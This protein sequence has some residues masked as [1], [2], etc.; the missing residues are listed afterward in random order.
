MAK[1]LVE[2]NM[3][4]SIYTFGT[5]YL[6]GYSPDR[7]QWARDL[8]LISELH[9]NT[10]RVWL[11]WGILEPADGQVDFDYIDEI[12]KLA[13]QNHLR[14]IFL[15]HLH[16]APEWA[17]RKHRDCWYVDQHG[18]PFE[19]SAR[20]NTPSGGWPG[21]CPDHVVVQQLEE[22]F[23]K[24]VCEYVGDRAFA[25]EPINEPHAWVDMAQNP[26]G[27]FCF[28]EETR[29]LFR[30]WL[31]RRYG[32]LEALEKAWGH[33]FTDWQ[34]VRPPTWLFGYADTVDWRLFMTENI[35]ELVKRRTDCIRRYS[36]VQVIAHAWGGGTVTC[37]QLG[38]MAFD[39]WKNSQSLDKWGCSAFP[40]SIK[41]T[42]NV[43][44]SMDAT[45]SAAC[46]KEFWQSEL[47]AGDV[48]GGLRRGF[49]T[50]PE[51]FS[52]WC[53][54]AIGH[55]SK[56]L[57]FWQFRKESYGNESGAYGLTDYQGNPSPRALAA[58]K[59]AKTLN[60]HAELF[61]MAEMPQSE[62]A[63]LFSYQSIMLNWAEFRNNNLS[64]D[65]I[66]GYYRAF[67]EQN[68][69]VDI[70]HEEFTTAE[71]LARYKLVVLPCP[72]TLPQRITELLKD[73]ATNGGTVLSDPMLCLWDE[74]QRLSDHVPGNGLHTLFG[75]EEKSLATGSQNAFDVFANGRKIS[76]KNSFARE[77]WN[78]ARSD[79]RT[80]VANG[81]GEAMVVD[82]PCGAGHAVLSGLSLGNMASQQVSISDD[83]H[84]EGAEQVNEGASE[85]IL[86]VAN[87]AGVACP[88][89]TAPNIR[90][91]H[92]VSGRH[93]ILIAYDFQR[94]EAECA[95]R[96]TAAGNSPWK[97][98]LD[99]SEGVFRNGETMLSFKPNEIKVMLL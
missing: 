5:Q 30:A 19:P 3:E 53:W 69:P 10:I 38:T 1:S 88:F 78:V 72:F 85:L 48:S 33:R 41:H 34:D 79:V 75:C 32:T 14:V 94:K 44:L 16:S 25:Y 45:R 65:A 57:L 42:C 54:E 2:N 96:F 68:I 82:A 92:L 23:I 21:L 98:L 24:A 62:V 67:W 76:L 71:T 80:L 18:R 40:S 83:F 93:H 58:S 47:S 29:N 63:I 52:I 12:L 86:E 37:G 17:I 26:Q 27:Y 15:F 9:F 51:T 31:Q 60:D 59:I 73:F 11:V 22:R 95:F 46:G 87:L 61:N 66:G 70:L 84:R 55:G 8:R 13:E 43:G 7:S 49:Y 91:R 74:H 99:G 39:D 89:E 56:G 81:E 35:A 4:N 36:R 64:V 77:T 28:C 6:R 20:A 97:N 90:V 50:S